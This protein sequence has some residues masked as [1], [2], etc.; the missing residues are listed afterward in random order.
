MKTNLPN[1]ETR[2]THATAN[3]ANGD[4]QDHL[5]S[6]RLSYLVENAVPAAEQ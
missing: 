1:L 5:R 2:A 4:L 6:L 3:T